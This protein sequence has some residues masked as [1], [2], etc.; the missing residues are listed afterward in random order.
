LSGRAPPLQGGGRWFETTSAHGKPAGQR[1]LSAN[2][3][4]RRGRWVPRGSRT[5]QCV[6]SLSGRSGQCVEPF[7]D[8]LVASR[9]Q[10]RVPVRG[11][12]GSVARA[13]ADLA[14]GRART[15][16]AMDAAECRSPWKVTAPGGGRES[17][18]VLDPR[19]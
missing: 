1:P 18:D 2:R 5:V 4:H 7:S 14:N 19:G 17:F 16:A 12:D 9:E 3:D 11:D 6:R 15:V 8:G 13:R 10:V